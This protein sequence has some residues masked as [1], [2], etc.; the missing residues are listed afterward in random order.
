MPLTIELPA[1]EDIVEF[2]VRRPS[3]V[4]ADPARARFGS[5]R[6]EHVRNSG[7]MPSLGPGHEL[8]RPALCP[9]FPGAAG[10]A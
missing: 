1:R 3:E 5:H 9:G 6:F 4:P 7:H 2:H 8:P 10:I